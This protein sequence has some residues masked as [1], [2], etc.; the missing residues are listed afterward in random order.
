MKKYN[1]VILGATGAVGIEF[2]KIL[3]DAEIVKSKDD[4]SLCFHS[5][6]HSFVSALKS[7]GANESVAMEL[8]GHR[9]SMISRNYTH[10]GDDVLARAIA[11]LPN[12]K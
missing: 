9:S 3:L 1:V 2:R 11:K 6:R 7:T 12:I 10:L 5:L 4:F 8:A